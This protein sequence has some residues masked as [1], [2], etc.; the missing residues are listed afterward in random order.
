MLYIPVNICSAISGCFQGA[1]TV[2]PDLNSHSN[3]DKKLV[4]KTDY[5]LMQVIS[6]A[7]CSN[8]EHSAIFFF[9]ALSDNQSL[10]PL[11]SIFLNGHLRQVLL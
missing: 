11:F 1:T 7:E 2:K 10:G 6:I 5:Y 9:P 3:E 4:F 8:R